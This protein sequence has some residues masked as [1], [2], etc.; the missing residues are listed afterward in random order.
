MEF[1]RLP[2]VLARRQRSKASHY[3]DIAAGLCTRPVRIGLRAVCWPTVEIEALQA[4][5]VRGASDQEV[6]A[7]VEELHAKRLTAGLEREAA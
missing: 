6:R 7:L 1:L 5:R 4:A 2:V 3:S